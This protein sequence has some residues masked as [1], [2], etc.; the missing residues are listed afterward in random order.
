M[1]LKLA[2]GSHTV[3]LRNPGFESYRQVIRITDGQSV[4][5]SHDF[6]AR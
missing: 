2:P 5:L 3:E 1:L 4:T 6:D